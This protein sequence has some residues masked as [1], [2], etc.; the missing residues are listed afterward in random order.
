MDS[1]SHSTS[2]F[3]HESFRRWHSSVLPLC[4][5]VLHK[6]KISTGPENQ[7]YIFFRGDHLFFNLLNS[8]ISLAFLSFSFRSLRFLS[9]SVPFYAGSRKICVGLIRSEHPR[10]GQKKMSA[11]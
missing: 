10:H 1:A 3:G 8:L 7:S 4:P 6:K 5:S 9:R 2:L 11:L